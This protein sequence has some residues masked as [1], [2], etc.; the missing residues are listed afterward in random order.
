MM[1]GEK[2]KEYDFFEKPREVPSNMRVVE[3][4]NG[5]RWGIVHDQHIQSLLLE[6]VQKAKE[7]LNKNQVALKQSINIKELNSLYDNLKGAVMI[8]YPGYYGLPVY[9]P[10]LQI[11]E[12]Q[13]Q[14]E[15]TVNDNFDYF[16][17]A[18]DM[19]IWWAGKEFQKGKKLKD[20]VGKNEKTKI[21]IRI[22]RPSQ[23]PPV[24]E[25]AVDAESQKKMMSYYYKKQEEQ[26]K[27][28]EENDDY[29]LNSVW[30][31]P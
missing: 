1:P 18:T 16:K 6:N 24:R 21:I 5:F 23:G 30:A 14:Y 22:Q 2:R 13:Y 3:D 19:T 29:Y 4:K 28:E 27:L 10:V 9:E 11:L 7:Y 15:T 26:K 25:P 31:N 12:N 20:I 8:A 17:D